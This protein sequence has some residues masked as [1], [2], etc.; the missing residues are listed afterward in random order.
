M[1]HPSHSA[2]NSPPKAPS[3]PVPSRTHNDR[4]DQR[5]EGWRRRRCRHHHRQQQ[6][7]QQQHHH[8][9]HHHHHEGHQP[10]HQ[11]HHQQQQQQQQEQRWGWR[12]GPRLQQVDKG[13]LVRVMNTIL[14]SSVFLFLLCFHFCRD[15][16]PSHVSFAVT[17][18]RLPCVTGVCSLLNSRFFAAPL[19][20]L[21][22]AWTSKGQVFTSFATSRRAAKSHSANINSRMQN[23]KC[24]SP[25]SRLFLL[26]PPPP[27]AQPSKHFDNSIDCF[28]K[29]IRDEGFRGL[30]NLAASRGSNTTHHRWE[31][32]DNVPICIVGNKS[33][34]KPN[35]SRDMSGLT[36]FLCCCW[37][38]L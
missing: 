16:P 20:L 38:D 6:Q 33:V 35:N 9:H 10:Q 5:R 23:R 28:R 8:H 34:P 15:L 32:T 22:M 27:G 29:V 13:R 18:L 25:G 36:I 21:L 14:A 2:S 24:A 12:R 30:L 3:P 1:L 19:S 17:Y 31:E 37:R 11:Q 7:Q 4:K 26:A